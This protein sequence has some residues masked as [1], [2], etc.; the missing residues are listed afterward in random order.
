MFSY[1]VVFDDDAF[2]NSFTVCQLLPHTPLKEE[3][4][5]RV[6]EA[7]PTEHD[8]VYVLECGEET[9]NAL[10]DGDAGVLPRPWAESKGGCER[11]KV[12][13]RKTCPLHISS[14]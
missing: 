3:R 12:V 2:A 1:R 13:L 11:V 6:T 9:W 10:A 5:T 14:F 8:A 4:F 7:S